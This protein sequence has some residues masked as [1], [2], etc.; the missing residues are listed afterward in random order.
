[1]NTASSP[2]PLPTATAK[3]SVSNR[4]G[5]KP[6]GSISLLGVWTR[7]GFSGFRHSVDG[8][9]SLYSGMLDVQVPYS[10]SWSLM[11]DF[12]GFLTMLGHPGGTLSPVS[13]AESNMS[14]V[15]LVAFVAEHFERGTASVLSLMCYYQTF[16]RIYVS[17]GVRKPDISV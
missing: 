16:V 5:E 3:F 11:V 1:M 7:T 15:R 17:F 14:S 2:K 13:Q 4:S 12:F 9:F 8:V 10:L 6:S